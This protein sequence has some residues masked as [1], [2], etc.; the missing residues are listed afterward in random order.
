MLDVKS[1]K[2]ILH[3]TPSMHD[4]VKQA[5]EREGVS[6]AEYIR[7]ALQ[8]R[9]ETACA[10]ELVKESLLASMETRREY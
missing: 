4:A 3:V 9:I 5:A 10:V 6:M 2:L 1:K 8:Q 7:G